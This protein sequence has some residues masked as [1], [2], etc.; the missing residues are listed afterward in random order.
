MIEEVRVVRAI[1][2]MKV[3]SEHVGLFFDE[4]L[5]LALIQIANQRDMIELKKMHV[6]KL[7][8]GFEES[9]GALENAGI[10]L[11]LALMIFRSQRR[12]VDKHFRGVRNRV[13]LGLGSPISE[14]DIFGRSII[15]PIAKHFG[16]GFRRLMRKDQVENGIH[17]DGG[18][19]LASFSNS[20]SAMPTT[21]SM[22]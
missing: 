19:R 9:G 20:A 5:D 2:T 13:E 17:A 15:I 22:L 10:T 7:G 11:E 21:W 14:E 18:W 16:N 3:K 1:Y 4:L 12:I 8:T 6:L